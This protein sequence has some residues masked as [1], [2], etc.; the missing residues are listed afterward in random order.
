MGIKDAHRT[1]SRLSQILIQDD[2]AKFWVKANRTWSF[3]LPGKFLSQNLSSP[4][5]EAGELW[6]GAH[7]KESRFMA[8]GRCSLGGD[9]GYNRCPPNARLILNSQGACLGPLPWQELKGD[10]TLQ[11]RARARAGR[12][13]QVGVPVRRGGGAYKALSIPE[14]ERPGAACAGGRGGP[15]PSAR[16]ST[17]QGTP[18]QASG[19]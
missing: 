5:L 19:Y 11:G 3:L 4:S 8:E 1:P 13:A 17:V 9:P 15:Q 14:A 12:V 10:L 7:T 16:C 6:A 2:A 18:V